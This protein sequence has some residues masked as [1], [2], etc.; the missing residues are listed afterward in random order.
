MTCLLVDAGAAPADCLGL[1]A[2]TLSRR[3]ESDVVVAMLVVVLVEAALRADIDA[4][5]GQG[6]HDLPRRQ[7]C[8]FWLIA[9]G[10]IRWR[11]SSV[12]R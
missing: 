1:T 3:H 4:P 2:V 6:R 9:G 7:S 5:I 10:R 8:K 11:S 12:R